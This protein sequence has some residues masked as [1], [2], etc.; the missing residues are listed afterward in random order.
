MTLSE[1]NARPGLPGLEFARGDA[2][3][4]RADFSLLLQQIGSPDFFGFLDSAPS[5]GNEFLQDYLTHLLLPVDLPAIAEACG[6]TLRLEIRELVAQDRRL[7]QQLG[8]TAFASPSRQ[9]GQLQLARLRP[10][11][12][13]R[14]VRRYL[15]AVESG[16]AAGWHTLVYGVTLALYSLPLRQGLLHYARETLASLAK[17]A[18]SNEGAANLDLLMAQVPA[19][20]E[21]AL[22]SC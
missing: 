22:A 7:A 17:N 18:G 14:I 12:D 13:E 21:A 20:V 10:L 6:H 11:R 8:A 19:A 4:L 3:S 16:R 15:A 2:A 5:P 1:K 9:I